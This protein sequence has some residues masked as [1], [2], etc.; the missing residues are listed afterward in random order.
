MAKR[1]RIRV[2]RSNLQGSNLQRS[3]LQRSNLPYN[4]RLGRTTD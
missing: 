4:E 2:Q 3:N 1:P